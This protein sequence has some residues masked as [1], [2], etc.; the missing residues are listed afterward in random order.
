[1]DETRTRFCAAI[2]AS[3]RANSKEVRRSLCLPTP[4]VK[5]NRFGT[6][7]FPNSYPSFESVVPLRFDADRDDTA[8]VRNVHSAVLI[9]EESLSDPGGSWRESH[10]QSKWPEGKNR[11][12]WLVLSHI[13]GGGSR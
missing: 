10:P 5:N 6:M 8:H 1:M 11:A 7:L 12:V 9:L 3:R 4:F 2:P 13:S